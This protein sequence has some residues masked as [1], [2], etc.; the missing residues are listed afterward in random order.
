MAFI[1]KED[2][3]ITDNKSIRFPISLIDEIEKF[4]EG[5]NTS[6]SAFVIQACEYALENIDKDE[7]NISKNK[8]N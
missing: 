4:I 7:K 5:K 1:L 8:S 3:G 6:F 2:R